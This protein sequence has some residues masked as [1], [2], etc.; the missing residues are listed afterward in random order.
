MLQKRGGVEPRNAPVST[1][2]RMN[3]EQTMMRS[4]RSDD[5]LDGREAIHLVQA[6][7]ARYERLDRFRRRSLPLWTDRQRAEFTGND[8][9]PRCGRPGILPPPEFLRDARIQLPVNDL[10]ER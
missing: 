7:E 8:S 4:R 3:P 10:E 5:S 2:E 9:L 6:A 1:D